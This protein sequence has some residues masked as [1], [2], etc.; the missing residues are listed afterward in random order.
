[1]PV[2]FLKLFR[3]GALDGLTSVK[4]VFPLILLIL[5]FSTK[6]LWEMLMFY[7]RYS[8]YRQKRSSSWN[9]N[10]PTTGVGVASSSN[11]LGGRGAI[12]M[13][14][15]D[16][17]VLYCWKSSEFWPLPDPCCHLVYQARWRLA[18]SRPGQ[19]SVLLGL[20]QWVTFQQAQPSSPSWTRSSSPY[21]GAVDPEPCST[22][23]TTSATSPGWST[24]GTGPCLD[25]PGIGGQDDAYS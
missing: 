25:Q 10:H 22:T 9:V 11:C 17:V 24:V 8:L 12:W 20:R 15:V 2:R 5:N 3:S 4:I 6:Q 16:L 13:P 21:P 14:W 19:L 23:S 7:C 1:M 18:V